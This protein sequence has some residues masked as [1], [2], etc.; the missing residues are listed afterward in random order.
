MSKTGCPVFH[1]NT[2]LWY[3]NLLPKLLQIPDPTIWISKGIYLSHV[4][5]NGEIKPF[6]R[7]KAEFN[8][9]NYILF[10][11]FQVRHA[12][13]AQFAG[14]YPSLLSVDVLDVL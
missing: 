7:S 2:P 11:F 10:H 3:N 4:L 9:P 12:L 1:N 13:H 5:H 14:T 8:L 6:D